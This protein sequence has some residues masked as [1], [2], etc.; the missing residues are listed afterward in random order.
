MINTQTLKGNLINQDYST[1]FTLN[2]GDKGVPFKVELLENGTPYTL[3]STDIVTIEWLKPNGNPFLQ[4]GDI[5]YGT[6]YIEFTTPE[7]I[8]QCN[9]SGSFNIIISNGDLRKGTIRR[10]YK[11]IPTSFKPGSISEDVITDAI[12]ELRE[13]SLEIA[14]LVQNNQDLINNNQAATKQDI[15]NINSSLEDITKIIDYSKKNTRLL[16]N[17]LQKL[18]KHIAITVICNGDS[19]TYGQDT[20]SSDKRSADTTTCDDGSSHTQTRAGKTYPERLKECLDII[21]PDVSH[22]VINKGYSGDYAQ[23]SYNRWNVNSNADIALIMLGTN[24]AHQGAS[25]VSSDVQG[26]IDKYLTYMRKIIERYLLWGTAVVLLTPPRQLNQENGI[27]GRLTE[28]YRSALYILG[29]EYNAPVIDT[30]EFSNGWDATYWCDTTHFNTKGYTA[31]ADR[32]SSIFVGYGLTNNDWILHTGESL[33][34]RYTRDNMAY[35]SVTFGEDASSNGAEE[36]TDNKGLTCNINGNGKLVY[37]FKT[38]EDNIIIVPVYSTWGNQRLKFTL[39]FDSEQGSVPLLNEINKTNRFYKPSSSFTTPKVQTYNTNNLYF[40]LIKKAYD[41]KQFL[42]IANKG[43]HNLVVNNIDTS[44]SYSAIIGF[45]VLSYKDFYTL[46]TSLN[47]TYVLQ[48]LTHDSWSATPNEVST[49][50][51]TVDEL[52][53]FFKNHKISSGEYYKE[54]LMKITLTSASK[55]YVQEYVFTWHDDGGETAPTSGF[56]AKELNNFALYGTPEN[57]RYI[58]SVTYDSTNRKYVIN[59]SGNL[60]TFGSIIVKPL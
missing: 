3:Q 56:Y 23:I 53:S 2:Q 33:G 45:I 39:D 14:D 10:E 11:V 49:M 42:H 51:I 4:E 25:W 38:L 32:L 18:S 26:S 12:T 59:F 16:S 34:V 15:S 13:L 27:T 29:K 1:A 28:S 8:A 24:D 7:A 36:Y 17:T 19:L 57:Y 40:S 41:D 48:K 20:V 46:A 44:N 37:S 54:I 52:N 30:E 5:L 21:Y 31:F 43:I 6:T 55:G 35:Y 47:T 22:A 58:D 50:D 60:N 9:G